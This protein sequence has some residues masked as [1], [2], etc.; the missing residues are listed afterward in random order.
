[1]VRFNDEHRRILE[2]MHL[3]M[4]LVPMK[5]TMNCLEDGFYLSGSKN[6]V[7]GFS[8]VLSSSV[9]TLEKKGFLKVDGKTGDY[10]I[11]RKGKIK[12]CVEKRAPRRKK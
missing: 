7:H 8:E 6:G 2:A 10:I 1:M 9:I 3:G 12:I 4:R 11:T 5:S